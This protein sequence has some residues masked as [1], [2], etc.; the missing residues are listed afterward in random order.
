MGVC[1]SPSTNIRIIKQQNQ[2]EIKKT[3]IIQQ[4]SFSQIKQNKTKIKNMLINIM[5]VKERFLNTN[6]KEVFHNW[7]RKILINIPY[8]FESNFKNSIFKLGSKQNIIKTIFNIIV[9]YKE[10][11]TYMN[12]NYQKSQQNLNKDGI[13]NMKDSFISTKLP[14]NNQLSLKNDSLTCNI[15]HEKSFKLTFFSLH[16]QQFH[17]NL[18]LIQTNNSFFSCGQIYTLHNKYYID[19]NVKLGKGAFSTVYSA[20]DSKNKKYAVKHILKSRSYSPSS[21]N[22]TIVNKDDIIDNEIFILKRIIRAPK[23]NFIIKVYDIYE[24]KG[25]IFIVMEYLDSTLNNLIQEFNNKKLIDEFLIWKII[26][27]LV[28][29]ID[30]CHN[31]VFIT[32]SD[33]HPKNILLSNDKQNVKLCDFGLAKAEEEMSFQFNLNNTLLKRN[34][35]IRKKKQNVFNGYLKP[36]EVIENSIKSIYNVKNMKTNVFNNMASNPQKKI[37]ITNNNSIS[38]LHNNG[39]LIYKNIKE[40]SLFSENGYTNNQIVSTNLLLNYENRKA[41]D[42]WMLGVTIYWILHGNINCFEIDNDNNTYKFYLDD[43]KSIEN[44]NIDKNLI[45]LMENL[46]SFDPKERYTVEE[47]KNCKYITKNNMYPLYEMRD[48]N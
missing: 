4:Q 18:D 19:K 35:S 36:P 27:G 32:H 25:D 48:N 17:L 2:D 28:M 5:P 16:Q 44:G 23:S 7:R 11:N 24:D 1:I 34:S 13:N 37:N 42:M 39:S 12:L 3:E 20:I 41:I 21:M 26:R 47:V 6:T 30:Y 46:L 22:N 43:E 15:L 9:T 29:S 31:T 10:A 33:I 38:F 14:L 8:L 45:N 40:K